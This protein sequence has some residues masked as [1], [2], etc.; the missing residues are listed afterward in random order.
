MK[1]LAY[2]LVVL[3]GAL[4]VAQAAPKDQAQD[5]QPQVIAAEET[6]VE[7]IPAEPAK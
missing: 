5:Q 1:S 4:T 2:T 7:E 3:F 6:V